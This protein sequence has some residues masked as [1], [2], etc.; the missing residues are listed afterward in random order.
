MFADD[1]YKTTTDLIR[2]Y[3]TNDPFKLADNMGIMVQMCDNFKT[4]KGIYMVIKRK[5]VIMINA[6]LPVRKQRIV[7]AHEIGH[8]MMHRSLAK[9]NVL[10]EF[11]LYDMTARTEYEANMFA[12][13]ILI[14]DQ[15]VLELACHY[16]YDMEQIA[17]ALNS[18]INL[19]GIKI[20]NM[21]YRGSGLNIGIDPKKN[22]LSES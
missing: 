1:V 11:M 14:S 9:N 7:C 4:L 8:D 10:Q 12:A 15:E 13:D 6:N 21:N 2:K 16:G 5:R 20:G 22:F 3:G 19:I 17:K 18:D